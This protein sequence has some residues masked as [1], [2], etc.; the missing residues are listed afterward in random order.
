MCTIFFFLIIVLHTVNILG[1]GIWTCCI[2]KCMHV[3]RFCHTRN[4]MLSLDS[5][6][7]FSIDIS[8]ERLQTS[9]QCSM[10]ILKKNHLGLNSSFFCYFPLKW[11]FFPYFKQ[12]TNVSQCLECVSWNLLYLHPLYGGCRLYQLTSKCLQIDENVWSREK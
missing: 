5:T 7:R 1:R 11:I 9:C 10:A 6:E 4:V 2:P 3:C 12:E 8:T